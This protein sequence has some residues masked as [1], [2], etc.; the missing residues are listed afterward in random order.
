MASVLL[1]R[2]NQS[3]VGPIAGNYLAVPCVNVSS[4]A[5]ADDDLRLVEKLEAGKQEC[6]S[7]K[8]QGGSQHSWPWGLL[9]AKQGNHDDLEEHEGCDDV[10]EDLH[11]HLQHTAE[12][13]SVNFNKPQY[14]CKTFQ[15]KVCAL[16]V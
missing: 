2:V 9:D 8:G 14:D 12:S 7:D 11:P 3:A 16:R 1:I 15:T 4:T 13:I 5:V 6:Q 10:L